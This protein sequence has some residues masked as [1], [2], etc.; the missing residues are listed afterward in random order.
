MTPCSNHVYCAGISRIERGYRPRS[1]CSFATLAEWRKCMADYATGRWD[2]KRGLFPG[3]K[4][5]S[6][7][8]GHGRIIRLQRDNR[9][10]CHNRRIAEGDQDRADHPSCPHR[11]GSSLQSKGTISFVWRCN[12]E[13][14]EGS[15]QGPR[16]M[17]KG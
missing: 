11:L 3:G 16:T 14:L 4:Q 2:G 7:G 10:H 1:C 12:S 13:Q 9:P 8:P 15:C 6:I 17:G 5:C